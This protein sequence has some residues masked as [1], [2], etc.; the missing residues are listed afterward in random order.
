MY[1]AG[2]TQST[3]FLVTPGALQTTN[4]G[5]NEGWAAKTNFSAATSC[6]APTAD[7]TV[8]ICAPANGTTVDTPVHVSAAAADSNAVKAM[9]IYVDGVKKFE[10]P[11]TKGIDTF[12][13]MTSGSHRVTV[14]AVDAAG[15]F[16]SSVTITVSSA[17]ACTAPN[18]G[19]LNLVVCK[20]QDNAVVASPVEVEA[21]ASSPSGI[22]LMR[23]KV[24]GINGVTKFETTANHFDTFIAMD[25]GTRNVWV[26]AFDNSGSSTGGATFITVTGG[27]GGCSV[28]ST[29][30]TVNI[31]APANGATV[32]SPVHVTAAAKAGSSAI[33]VMQVYVDGVKKF[34]QANVT[35][36]DTSIGMAAGAHRVTVQAIDSAGAFKST[37]NITVQ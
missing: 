28:P 36:V 25:P 6:T 8:K 4:H 12:V 30:R 22:K 7:R 32:S 20:P 29:A 2:N 3:N 10:Q 23:V 27:S 1:V 18:N 34:E 5:N 33:K 16:K 35:S 24:D 9:Q 31:C 26:E 19:Q 37:V 15:A 17:S 21:S 13:T 11:N 14:Q